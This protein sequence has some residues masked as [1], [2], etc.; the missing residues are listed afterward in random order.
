MKAT[1]TTLSKLT[2]N[3][4]GVLSGIPTYF[5][6]ILGLPIYRADGSYIGGG[7]FVA[8]RIPTPSWDAAQLDSHADECE[9]WELV[10]VLG[11]YAIVT[12]IKR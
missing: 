11:D 6:N 1:T 12:V 2:G 8:T 4:Y 10:G 7:D 3:D 5:P 9:S